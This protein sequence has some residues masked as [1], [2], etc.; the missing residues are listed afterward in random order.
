MENRELKYLFSVKG[1]ILSVIALAAAVTAI[2]LSVSLSETYGSVTNYSANIVRS[3]TSS[4]EESGSTPVMGYKELSYAYRAL[5]STCVEWTDA[6]DVGKE[7]E[8]GLYFISKENLQYCIYDSDSEA[9]CGGTHKL[10]DFNYMWL[11]S[12]D[13]D[14][15]VIVNLAGKN[16]DLSGYYVLARDSGYL[17]ASRVLINCYEAETVDLT[18]AVLT[19]TLLAP[20]ANVKYDGTYVYGQV[21]SD[22]VSGT[23]LTYREIRFS[24]YYS[25]M[26]SQDEAAFVN[27]AVRSA[28][29][30]YLM[31]HNEN[32]LYDG[33]T[34][35]SKVRKSDL[36]AIKELDVSGSI[37]KGDISGDIAKLSNLEVLRLSRTNLTSLTLPSL[38]AL[39]EL[40]MNDT[41]VV[42]VDLRGAPGL[43]RLS[44]E[45]TSLKE[46]GLDE[47]KEL[48]IL[49]LAGSP[50]EKFPQAQLGS[51]EYLD[52]S[53]AA[54]NEKVVTGFAMSSLKTLLINSNPDLQGLNVPS[55]VSLENIDA[56]DTGIS[57]FHVLA[58][59][60]L[61]YIRLN[62]TKIL[63]LDLTNIKHLY[64]CECYSESLMNLVV[65]RYA[66]KLY[67][68]VT[69]TVM[70][71]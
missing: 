51:L 34:K 46:I 38:P 55:F 62:D 19:G 40:E 18:G 43:M 22:N 5:S 16:I 9:L 57:E 10:T 1:I 52:I 33:Y 50:I 26:G 65:N 3:S 35:D 8:S 32:G 14:F 21:L 39:R 47:N 56:S 66:D 13:N 36:G 12:E 17:Y 23:P 54:L 63:N 11:N 4:S 70:Q 71:S 2:V 20:Y 42:S 59:A 67:T 30:A 45:N 44:L 37:L 60:K 6:D 29:V 31:S 15:Y 64:L 7:G 48:R 53:N 61:V 28:A 24:G 58:N 49:I 69:P 25:V 68:N 41:P 27:D